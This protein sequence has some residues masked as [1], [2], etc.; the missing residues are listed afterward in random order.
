MEGKGEGSGAEEEAA[1]AAEVADAASGCCIGLGWRGLGG[2][3]AAKGGVEFDEALRVFLARRSSAIWCLA[4]RSCSC[5][6]GVSDCIHG[7][8]ADRNFEVGLPASLQGPACD[9]RCRTE[10]KMFAI[11]MEAVSR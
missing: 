8:N 11:W 5:E 4:S 10:S 2:E 3:S 6:C 9:I 7:L 1:V